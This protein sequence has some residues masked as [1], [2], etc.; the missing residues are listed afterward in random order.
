MEVLE[1]DK[2]FLEHFGTRGMKWGVRKNASTGPTEVVVTERPGKGLKTS[3]GK[4]QSA[5]EEAK[6]AAATRQKAK[7]SRVQSLSNAELQ[8]AVKRMQ[9]EQQFT[10]LSSQQSNTKVKKGSKFVK[11]LIKESLGLGK[12][13]NEVVKFDSSPAGQ[14]LRSEIQ[15]AKD[16]SN[17]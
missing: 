8:T 16:R 2:E 14:G 7:A 1:E 6:G 15:K 4:G 9:L 5:S 10:Q 11:G 13:A 17:E 3:G 12:T